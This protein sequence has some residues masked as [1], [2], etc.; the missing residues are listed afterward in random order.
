MNNKQLDRDAY[1]A[2]WNYLEEVQEHWEDSEEAYLRGYELDALES[3]QE[4]EAR[5]G[6]E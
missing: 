6:A 4:F 1:L 5:S 2:Y 3:N